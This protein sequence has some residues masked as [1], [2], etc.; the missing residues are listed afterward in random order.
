MIKVSII[1]NN[2]LALNNRIFDRNLLNESQWKGN[3]H[4][5]DSY[6][7]WY[8]NALIKNIELATYD[9][10][11]PKG[12]DVIFFIDLPEQRKTIE[13]IKKES[14]HATFI[15]LAL[16]SPLAPH[17]LDK[18]N[19]IDF[20]Y[21]ITYNPN[22][23][24]NTK[25]F[26]FHIPCS[27]IPEELASLNWEVRK[28]CV[29]LNSNYYRGFRVG[30]TPF[31]FFQK[32]KKRKKNG[33]HINLATAI[34]DELSMLYNERRKFIKTAN[35]FFPGFIDVFGKGWEGNK[36]SWFYRFF[37][38]KPFS[39]S[40]KFFEGEKLDLLKNYRYV[41]AF[42]NYKGSIGYIS[43]KIFDVMLAG[44]IPIYLGEKNISKYIPENCYIDAGLFKSYKQLITYIKNIDNKEWL[45]K[46]NSIDK[47]LN[48][49]NI[50]IFLPGKFAE[51]LNAVII[52]AHNN[53]N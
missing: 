2:T 8:N 51:T 16:E 36:Y 11:K 10:I 53:K 6:I 27:N 31:D 41:L 42:E 44:A 38:D 52:K 33:W 13:N 9:I 12:A 28:E 35:K 32:Q 22:L 5:M 49:K 39:E 25:Y 19:H 37:P 21:V 29:I 15:L 7:E 26:Q 3:T 18:K 23:V 50:E 17:Y 1:T 45:Q 34:K 20:D 30:N 47:F 40:P 43:E 48:S 14:P 4:W 24:D 46:R